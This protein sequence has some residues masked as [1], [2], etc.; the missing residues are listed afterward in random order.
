ML[1]ADRVEAILNQLERAYVRDG[2]AGA[3]RICDRFGLG[4]EMLDV[5]A[6]NTFDEWARA[7]MRG[8]YQP[9]LTARKRSA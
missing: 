5:I 8:Q 2:L 9:R 3:A 4:R 7:E 1:S 6:A